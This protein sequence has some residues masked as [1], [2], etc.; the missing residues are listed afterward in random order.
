MTLR[1]H[2]ATPLRAADDV[3]EPL[4]RTPEKPSVSRMHAWRPREVALRWLGA[5]SAGQLGRF[6]NDIVA[7][8]FSVDERFR[9]RLRT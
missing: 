5:R 6:S 2:V 1:A 8:S 4:R 7:E 9:L 3:K